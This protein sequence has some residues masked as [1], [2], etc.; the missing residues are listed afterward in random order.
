M[1]LGT[2]D[3][4]DLKLGNLQ[5]D[6]VYL[7]EDLVWSN[8]T[9]DTDYQAVLDRATTL[10]YTLPSDPQKLIQNNLVLGLKSNGIWSKLDVFYVFANDGS[11]QFGTLNWKNPNLYQNTLVNS[12]SFTTN[13]GFASNGSSSYINTNFRLQ[14]NGVNYQQNSASFGYYIFSGGSV[15]STA[16]LGVRTGFNNQ[17][18]YEFRNRFVDINTNSQTNIG[19]STPDGFRL[20]NRSNSTTTNRYLNGTLNGTSSAVSST[21]S[22]ALFYILALSNNGTPILFSTSTEIMSVVF[23]GGDLSSEQSDFNTIITNYMTSI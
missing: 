2:N 22:D 4:N 20:F 23:I 10:G 12:P 16:R 8:F 21:P 3:I 18:T 1:K 5:V 17:H 15:D 11:Q 14:T 9:Y 13:Q 19:T 6:K 7:G